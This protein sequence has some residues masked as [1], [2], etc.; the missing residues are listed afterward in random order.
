MS[1][2]HK[3]MVSRYAEKLKKNIQL[4]HIPVILLTARADE[5]AG[6]QGFGNR[7]RCLYHKAFQR[8]ILRQIYC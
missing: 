4:A 8:K 2:C 7:S 5:E 1:P 6:R 3:W